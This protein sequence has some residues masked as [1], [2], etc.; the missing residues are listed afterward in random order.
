MV[1][2][3]QGKP[4]PTRMSNTLLPIVLETAMSPSPVLREAF[5]SNS[6][7][8]SRGLLYKGL[9]TIKK[10]SFCLIKHEGHY[11]YIT[12]TLSDCYHGVIAGVCNR[13]VHHPENLKV[14]QCLWT[15]MVWLGLQ[16]RY[17]KKDPV[18]CSPL[19]K[20]GWSERI[21]NYL[22][23]WCKGNCNDY[24]LYQKKAIQTLSFDG[25]IWHKNESDQMKINII[26]DQMQTFVASL[27]LHH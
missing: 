22:A 3:A 16:E 26:S 8:C 5:S 4:S 13:D 11:M 9:K 18:N 17:D 14:Q 7:S 23:P 12:C 2:N 19:N 10:F 21:A 24:F 27:S 20:Q 25:R 6:E 1:C 15:Q